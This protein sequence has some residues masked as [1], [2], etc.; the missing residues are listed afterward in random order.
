MEI[1]SKIILTDADAEQFGQ[2]MKRPDIEQIK[3]GEKFLH[4]YKN[5]IGH[6]TDGTFTAEIDDSKLESALEK[7]DE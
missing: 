2:M 7:A 5:K 6:E 1:D 4:G 3:A